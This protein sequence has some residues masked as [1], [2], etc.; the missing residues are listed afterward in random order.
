MEEKRETKGSHADG[1]Y[2]PVRPIFSQ[3]GLTAEEILGNGGP[4]REWSANGS[5]QLVECLTCRGTCVVRCCG[6]W[7]TCPVCEGSGKI[8]V[9]L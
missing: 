4:E 1:V 8:E 6:R 5:K 9:I 7:E 3:P 2:P